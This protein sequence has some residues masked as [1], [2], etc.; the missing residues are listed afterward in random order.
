[1]ALREISAKYIGTLGGGIWAIV[2]PITL[3]LIYWF[4]FSVGFKVKGPGDSPFVLYF[5]SGMLPWLAFNE[6]LMS[7]TYGITS[8]A[9]LVKKIVFPTEVLPVVYLVA[10]SV[11][12]V[13]LLVIVLSLAIFYGYGITIDVFQLIYYFTAL[14]IFTL[15]LSWTLSA[16]QV[17]SRDI[18]QSIA[19]VMNMWFWFTPIVW[20]VDI[21]P[22]RAQWILKLN[23]IYYIV[24]GYRD[25]IF[26][27]RG[28]LP[29]L[30]FAAYFWVVTIF[31][32]V[33]GALI[34]RKLK[35]D[36]ADMV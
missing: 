15:G 5:T 3:V 16:L 24:T 32:F 23:P 14:C 18:G 29:D 9:N 7:S 8:N 6:V 26:L 30:K 4:V 35:P 33:A 34:F 36:F 1:M 11:T 13:V 28:M 22:A 12:H 2:H 27:H 20:A 19:V 10:A 21:M 31:I 17:F 25:S